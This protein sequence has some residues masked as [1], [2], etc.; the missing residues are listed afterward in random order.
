MTSRYYNI[1]MPL[2]SVQIL[3]NT[4]QAGF[5]YNALVR[6]LSVSPHPPDTI[7][8]VI[9]ACLCAFLFVPLFVCRWQ[10]LRRKK[11]DEKANPLPD[12]VFPTR[13]YGP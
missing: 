3:L 11:D 4:F 6:R 8:P 7:Y 5:L 2:N 12:P 13:M 1:M 10:L 9:G